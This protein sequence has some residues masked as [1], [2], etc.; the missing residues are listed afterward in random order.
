MYCRQCAAEL[1][2]SW[3]KCPTCGKDV[4]RPTTPQPVRMRPIDKLVASMAVG[5]AVIFL[6]YVGL[7]SHPPAPEPEL[8]A[9]V[10]SPDSNQ[11]ADAATNAA[12][13][14]PPASHVKID[15]FAWQRSGS[16]CDASGRITN[17]SDR[18]LP[19]LKITA[20]FFKG[21]EML[22]SDWTFI[23][24]N[25]SFPPGTSSTWSQMYECPNGADRVELSAVADG[26]QLQVANNLHD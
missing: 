19:Y 3:I 6:L 1:Q 25:T 18:D 15:R 10:L 24:A 20:T 23:D 7:A 8:P 16:Y 13:A 2:P 14:V 11:M 4:S 12:A 9:L 26:Y 5:A 21:E 22:G 17:T